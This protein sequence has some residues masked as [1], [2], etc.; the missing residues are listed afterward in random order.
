M[1]KQASDHAISVIKAGL[2]A[3][4]G[5]GG[6]IASLIGDYVPSATERSTRLAMEELR[7]RIDSLGDRIDPGAVNQ[8]E[9]AELFKSCYLVIVRT[10]QQKN[11]APLFV[12]SRI[13]FCEKVIPINS[14]IQNSITLF[15]AWT[16]SLLALWKR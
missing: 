14:H 11:E 15:T 3:V 8:E 1:T 2:S 6:P 13:F 4:P 5:V 10:H 7:Q 9:F 16:S 12:L